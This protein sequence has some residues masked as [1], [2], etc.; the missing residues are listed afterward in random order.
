MLGSASMAIRAIM[1]YFCAVL[2]YCAI[3]RGLVRSF[4]VL[5][6]HWESLIEPLI[7]S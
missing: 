3:V 7:E 1:S 6:F 4:I 5:E 2:H